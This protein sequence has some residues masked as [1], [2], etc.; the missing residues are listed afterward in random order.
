M[1]DIHTHILP[2]MDDGS[3]DEAESLDMLEALGAQGIRLVVATPHFYPGENSPAEFLQRRTEAAERLRSVWHPG[4]PELRLGAEVC[5]FDGMSRTA[6]LDAL[7]IEGTELLLLEMPFQSWPDRLL[8]E[9]IKLHQRPGVTVVLAHI[10]RYLPE[11]KAAWDALTAAGVLTQCNA[12]FFLRWRT[13][14]RALRLL[15]QGR[16][17]FLGSDCHNMTSRPP[18]IGAAIEAA[19][20][21]R[22][23]TVEANIRGVFPIGDGA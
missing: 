22:L 18:R 11:R 1:I 15:E 4:L 21:S 5:C 13:R 23:H 16:I 20:G 10:E 8:R 14:R 3:W 6:E 2:G 12:G 9:V 17:H 7:R 19:G